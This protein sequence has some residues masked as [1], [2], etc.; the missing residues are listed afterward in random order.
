LIDRTSPEHCD[1]TVTTNNVNVAVP[2]V[3]LALTEEQVRTIVREEVAKA[4]SDIK[5][6]QH[7]MKQDRMSKGVMKAGEL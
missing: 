3:H 1:D 4:L 5:M 2:L 7:M 6:Q